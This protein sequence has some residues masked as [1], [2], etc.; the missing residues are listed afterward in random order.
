MHIHADAN[1]DVI[2]FLFYFLQLM[3]LFSWKFNTNITNI[4]FCFVMAIVTKARQHH[5][6]KTP[7]HSFPL[8]FFQ[9]VISLLVC[10]NNWLNIKPPFSCVVQSHCHGVSRELVPQVFMCKHDNMSSCHYIK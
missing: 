10:G 6:H 2:F 1:I 8:K 7:L 3:M 9:I 4:T 5:L